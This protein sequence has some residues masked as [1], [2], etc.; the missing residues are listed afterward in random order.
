[1]SRRQFVI[2]R[3][4][5]TRRILCKTFSDWKHS[6]RRTSFSKR[7]FR[8]K[9]YHWKT[10]QDGKYSSKHHGKTRDI[11]WETFQ[12][13]EMS[14]ENLWRWVGVLRWFYVY[15]HKYSIDI[16][17]GG[18]MPSIYLKKNEG[19]QFNM[20]KLQRTSDVLKTCCD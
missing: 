11:I 15:K 12:E 4:F 17:Q 7:F 3:L 8:T 18:E 19:W 9:K 6:W 5:K 1:M 13:V 2:V 20:N 16:L 10:Y 14:L